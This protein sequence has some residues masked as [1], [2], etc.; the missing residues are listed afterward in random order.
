MSNTTNPKRVLIG[1]PEVG[2]MLGCTAQTVRRWAD[3]G[4]IPGVRLPGGQWRFD[5]QAIEAMLDG[6]SA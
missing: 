6:V 2:E 3:Q 4:K 5:Q 1:S